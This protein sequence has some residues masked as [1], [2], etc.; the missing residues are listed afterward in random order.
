MNSNLSSENNREDVKEDVA[1]LKKRLNNV[2]QQLK[3]ATFHIRLR[4]FFILVSSP[5]H[6]LSNLRCLDDILNLIDAPILVRPPLSVR[7]AK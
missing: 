2:E 1:E 3:L 6:P 5:S 7:P 4:E